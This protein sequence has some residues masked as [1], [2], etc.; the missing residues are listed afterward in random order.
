CAV[1]NQGRSGIRPYR[2]IGSAW[3]RNERSQLCPFRHFAAAVML[4]IVIVS[5]ARASAAEQLPVTPGMLSGP[6]TFF[7]TQGGVEFAEPIPY[8]FVNNLSDNGWIWPNDNSGE[9]V[10]DFGVPTALVKF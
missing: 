10:V 8:G 3:P 7:A 9:L 6:L 2:F 1:E 5:G 4:A